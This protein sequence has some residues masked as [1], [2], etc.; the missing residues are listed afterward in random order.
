MLIKLLLIVSKENRDWIATLFL[1]AFL[2]TLLQK[3]DLLIQCFRNV[4]W[5]VSC[6]APKYFRDPTN[7]KGLIFKSGKLGLKVQSQSNY[8]GLQFGIRLY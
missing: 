7:R 6:S 3:N 5:C 8:I 1:I 2:L 4:K